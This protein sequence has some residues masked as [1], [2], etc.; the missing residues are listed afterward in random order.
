MAKKTNGQTN[1]KENEFIPL[2]TPVTV[3]RDFGNVHD[4]VFQEAIFRPDYIHRLPEGAKSAKIVGPNIAY[5]MDGL[6]HGY[7]QVPE[8]HGVAVPNYRQMGGYAGKLELKIV[9]LE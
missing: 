3:H 6:D 2:Q 1:G 5:S 7:T 8:G 9:Q 4:F